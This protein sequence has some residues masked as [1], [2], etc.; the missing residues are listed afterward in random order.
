MATLLESRLQNQESIFLVGMMAVG[1]TTIGKL[2]AEELSYSFYDTDDVIRKRSGADI[3]WI[4]EVE[5]EKGFRDR[6][7]QVI[8]EFTQKPSV[9]LA[10]GG[11]AI[12]R[13]SN[14][15]VLA[16]RGFVV[17]LFADLD[18]LA[19]RASIGDQ[20]PMLAN[21]DLKG[22]LADLIA[23]RGPMYSEVADIRIES[24]SSHPQKTVRELLRELFGGRRIK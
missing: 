8:E 16:A 23:E 1:K 19:T 13:E 22:R 6:E 17:Y 10:T 2:L 11:G 12:V 14:R 18:T 3:P 21:R 4:F 15:K 5:G 9:V 24:A 7:Q 20:R